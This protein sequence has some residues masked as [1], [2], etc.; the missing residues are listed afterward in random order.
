MARK[1]S[2]DAPAPFQGSTVH[3]WLFDSMGE[4]ADTCQAAG[5]KYH[6]NAP[7]QWA[8]GHTFEEAARAARDG[9][10]SGVAASDALLEKMERYSLATLKPTWENAISG[11]LPDVPAFIAGHPLSMRRK[12][13]AASEGAPIAIIADLTTSANINAAQAR[14]RGAAILALVRALSARRPVELWMTSGLDADNLR[15]AVFI[16]VK[17]D[18]APLDLAHAS[19]AMTHVGFPRQLL[20]GL[21]RGDFGFSGQWPFGHGALTRAQMEACLAPAFAHVTE[22]L[23]L[24]GIHVDDPMLTDPQ[25]WLAREIAAHDPLALVDA[26]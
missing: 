11:A 23:C 22:T 10:L 8:G 25:G 14:Q 13:R 19:H 26:A 6:H 17:I 5:T 18:T 7:A 16:S 3:H 21:A 20:Y 24:P 2:H 9:D 4:V 12:V 15:N 1:L